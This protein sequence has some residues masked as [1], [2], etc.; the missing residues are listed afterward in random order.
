MARKT[1][2]NKKK[3]NEPTTLPQSQEF[4]FNKADPEA[5]KLIEA[6]VAKIQK[7]HG[8]GSVMKLGENTT[9]KGIDVVPSGSLSLDLALGVGG[10]PRGRVVEIYGP[11]SC[12]AGESFLQYEVWAEG[13]RVNSKGGTIRRLFERF[14]NVHTDEEPKQGRRLQINDGAEF[15][16]KSV[17][18]KGRI[19]RNLVLDVVHTGLFP[20]YQVHTE[21]G[22]VLRCTLE[23]K[24]M[25]PGG[26]IPLANLEVG[27]EVFTHNNTRVRGR[28]YYPNRPETFVKYHPN[29]PTKIVH[30]NK[31]NKDYLYYRGQTSRLTYEA[32]LNGME[33][34]A[35][36]ET[37]NSSTKR[38]INEL[39]FLPDDIHVHHM[40]ENFKNN[41]LSNLQLVDPSEHGSIHAKDR[42]RNLSFIA[43]P[44][45]ITKIFLVGD[46]DTY[47]LR[48][49]YPYN[50]FIAEDI[51]VHNSGK[52][53]L[54]LHAIASA[55]KTGGICAFVDAEHALDIRYAKRLGVNIKDLL[56]SQPDY[57]E[58]GLEVV[59]SFVAGGGMSVIV[60]DSVAA[61]TP[62]AEIEGEMGDSH[63]GLQARLMSQAMRKLTA[64]VSKSNTLVIFINQTR[65][66]IGVMFGD[67]TT[68]S[69]GNALKF[70]ATVRLEIKR[71]GAV[72]SGTGEEKE[73]IGNRTKVR[74]VKNKVAPPFKIVEFDIIY[75]KGIS[76]AG[77]IL[78]LGVKN[79][80]VEKSGAWYSYGS[81]RLGQGRD[82]AVQFIENNPKIMDQIKSAILK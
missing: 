25:T 43:T 67:P 78:D 81:E 76:M 30:C 27:S 9:A 53:T 36:I 75:G 35:Y 52:T 38:E 61:L 71:I 79:S 3:T 13:K 41:D 20:C 23:H 63:M 10:L 24:F 39:T 22:Q 62:K 45:K 49:E 15:Y 2:P 33:F 8:I 72:K 70:Y 14:H 65:Q 77:D 80:I 50:N 82:S 68:T 55:Q 26:F 31:V 1:P 4:T 46:M 51:V 7:Q 21:T 17:D 73:F 5:V 42:I 32:F 44:S 57:G 19:L 11:E 56:V 29:L 74:I 64:N 40:D 34:G 18:D 59:D 6:T 60:V 58:Q 37:L 69:G 28:K 16:V 47:D 54:A 66:K 12:L 48:C